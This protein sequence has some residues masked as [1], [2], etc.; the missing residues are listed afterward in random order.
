M[1][2]VPP[3]QVPRRYRVASSPLTSCCGNRY[4]R[5]TPIIKNTSELGRP[6]PT[7]RTA[8]SVQDFITSCIADFSAK[9]MLPVPGTRSAYGPCFAQGRKYSNMLYSLCALRKR[10]L[11]CCDNWQRLDHIHVGINQNRLDTSDTHGPYSPKS[12]A[13]LRIS[14]RSASHTV[15]I[16]GGHRLCITENR[17]PFYDRKISKHK[18]EVRL[19][20]ASRKLGSYQPKYGEKF[21][22]AKRTSLHRT[23]N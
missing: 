7:K 9:T 2:S 10:F 16:L 6:E 21:G 5:L 14:R 19:R 17:G 3:A 18:T 22:S 23:E 11:V 15:E 20:P 12:M 13:R 4:D 1:H 8:C